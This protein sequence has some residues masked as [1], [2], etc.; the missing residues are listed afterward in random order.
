M[1]SLQASLCTQSE[2]MD[3]VSNFSGAPHKCGSPPKN[4][5]ILYSVITATPYQCSKVQNEHTFHMQTGEKMQ[6]PAM[7]GYLI[8]LQPVH[9]WMESS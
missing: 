5:K 9:A 3:E 4:G 6:C 7:Q 2:G 8:V 1:L